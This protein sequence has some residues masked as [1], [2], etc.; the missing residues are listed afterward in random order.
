M[1]IENLSGPTGKQRTL[2][3]PIHC[4]GIGLHSGCR[5]RMTIGPAPVDSGIVFIRTDAAGGTSAVTALWH[6][7][8]DTRLCTV[9]ANDRGVTVAT[10]EHLMAA[11][12][13]CGV[14]NA[15]VELDGPEVPIMDGSAAPFVFL[16]ECAGIVEQSAPRRV[17]RVLKPVA[18]RDGKASAGLSPGPGFSCSFEIDFPSRA[19]ARQAR[20]FRLIDGAFKREL[21]GAR[22]FG[23][24]KDVETMRA[25]G[26]AQGGSLDNAIVVDGDRILNRDGLRYA[27]EFVR[28]KILDSIGDLYLAGSRLVGHFHGHR[29]GHRLN[30]DLLHALFADSDAWRLE[31]AA[32]DADGEWTAPPLARTA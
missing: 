32:D 6:R 31:E 5:V 3:A 10:I 14:D 24:L 7:V 23:F 27:D 19:V 15:R 26:L 25:N 9:I 8:H 13:G 21:A 11:L 16:L 28:H 4:S 2:K 20:H 17:I 29:S 22:T 18:I 1:G 30:N 12:H